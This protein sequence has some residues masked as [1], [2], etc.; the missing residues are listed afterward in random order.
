MGYKVEVDTNDRDAVAKLLNVETLKGVDMDQVIT[1]E[2]KDPKCQDD[3][4]SISNVLDIAHTLKETSWS[5]SLTDKSL[6]ETGNDK[7]VIV[8]IKTQLLTILNLSGQQ[9]C[10]VMISSGM[11]TP[12][13]D[14]WTYCG[15]AVI[16][17]RRA[18]KLDP[19]PH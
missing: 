6:R 15:V 5:S 3:D 10:I 7:I 12:Y 1:M 8:F 14:C 18:L 9:Q 17:P 16:C 13:R 2:T 19:C 4:Q 11:S